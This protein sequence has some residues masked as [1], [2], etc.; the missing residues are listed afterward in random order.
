MTTPRYKVL[1]VDDELPALTNMQLV[2]NC[3]PEWQLVA[4]CHST[5]QARAILQTERVDLLL[6]DI[7]MP[8]QSGLDFAR[9]LINQ[10]SAPLIVFITAY[11]K[12]A[13]TAFELFALDYLL[14]PFDD[15]RF[16]AMLAR[17]AQSLS[18]AQQLVQQQ[19]QSAAMHDY[20]RERDAE[21]KGDETPVLS[22]V[23][24]RSSGKIERIDVHEII[25]LSA[26]ANYVEIHLLN[27]VILHRATISSMEVRL[28]KQDFLRLHR[29]SIVRADAIRRL[30]SGEEGVYVAVLNNGDRVRVSESYVKKVKHLFSTKFQ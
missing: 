14:K 1:I 29:T 9:E 23:V 3:H 12:H 10:E 5:A 24:I 16:A 27:R 19:T 18:K 7:E 30:E 17:A 15:E 28:P 22:H 21:T 11:N 26:A 20:F 8:T 13:V 6:L 2:L 25:W 4:S